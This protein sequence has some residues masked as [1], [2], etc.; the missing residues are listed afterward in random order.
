MTPKPEMLE[1][2]NIERLLGQYQTPCYVYSAS[3]IRNQYRKLAS[4]FPGFTV[5]YSLKANPNPAI[6]RILAGLGAG[7]ETSS[8]AEL[9][10]ALAAGFNP[11][12]IIM[13]GPAKSADDIGAAIR[14]GIYAIVVDSG[15]E[16]LQV[17]ALTQ[18][19]D[20]PQLALLRI[21][22]MEK[23]RSKEAMVGGPSKF[24]FDEEKVVSQVQGIKLDQTRIAGIQ[25]YSASQVLDSGF[26][27][28]HLEYVLE[29]AKRLAG[30]LKFKPEC[31]DFG[32]GF[33]V[34][35]AENEPELDLKPIAEVAHRLRADNREFLA[36]CRLLLESGRYLVAESGVFLTRIVRVKE[37][38]GKTFVITDAGMNAFSRPV[39]MQVRHPIR[40]LNRLGEPAAG[41]YEVCGPICTPL[42]CIGSDVP[43]PSPEPGDVVGVFNAGAYGYSMSLR[44]FMSLPHPKEILADQSK[45]TLTH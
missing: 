28:R 22:T 31:I 33:G 42:D 15:D 24:G 36:G 14:N 26:L 3:T 5:C 41:R 18:R 34:P 6:G 44:D 23:P 30:E 37:S 17:D 20:R 21:N 9:E 43:L 29:L 45:L 32:G 12:D 8:Q 25:V 16:L 10:S 4:A 2:I 40:L 1:N 38:R 11:R 7:A 39:F 35:Y 13:V 19:S 27:A